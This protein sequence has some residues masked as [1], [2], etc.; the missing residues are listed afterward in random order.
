MRSGLQCIANPVGL[1]LLQMMGSNDWIQFMLDLPM[2]AQPGDVFLY[3]SGGV[4][5]FSALIRK[6][7]GMSELDFARSELF[8]PLGI[9]NV[10]AAAGKGAW[11]FPRTISL[12]IDEIGNINKFL[13]EMTFEESGM[14]GFIKEKSGL[15]RISIRGAFISDK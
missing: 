14:A 4:H 5:L 11:T 9:N 6:T 10:E 12:E 1:T 8:G 3:N 7:A 2:A 15:G 13:V